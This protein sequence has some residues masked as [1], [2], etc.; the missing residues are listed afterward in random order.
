MLPVIQSTLSGLREYQRMIASVA[1]QLA[2]PVAIV[3]LQ[4]N[5]RSEVP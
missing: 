4:M 2:T 1:A 3:F 5:I